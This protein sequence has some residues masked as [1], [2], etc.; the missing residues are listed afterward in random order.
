MKF[1]EALYIYNGCKKKVFIEDISKIR[2]ENPAKFRDEIIGNLYC[3]EC[4][5]PKLSH[6]QCTGKP[7]YFAKYKKQDHKEGCI[8]S[9]NEASQTIVSKILNDENR[10]RLAN[11]LKNF[12]I[13]LHTPDK[14]QPH[15]L[16]YTKTNSKNIKKSTNQTNNNIVINYYLP[17]KRI[18]N[19][20]SPEDIKETKIYYGDVFI[21]W[22]LLQNRYLL[23]I[24]NTKNEY[25][26]SLFMSSNVYSYIDNKFKSDMKCSVAFFGKLTKSQKDGKIYYNININHSSEIQFLEIE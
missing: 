13:S 10:E 24:S 7:D 9:Y 12:L 14:I 22:K 15:P 16:V 1:E 25:I 8:F 18:T 11:R 5:S 4:H 23:S 21:K 3:P 2:N 19:K 17:R 20:L 26:C 6:H